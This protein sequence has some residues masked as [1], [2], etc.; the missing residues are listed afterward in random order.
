MR[1]SSG[2]GPDVQGVPAAAGTTRV[3]LLVTLRLYGHWALPELTNELARGP[4]AVDL[5]E[6]ATAA[7]L[8]DAL[9]EACGPRFRGKVFWPGGGLRPGVRL[10]VDDELMSDPTARIGGRLRR[11]ANVSVVL[12]APLLGG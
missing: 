10:F 2:T 12:L 9:G 1:S 11:G 4:V 8:L 3:K 5:P 6:H 7:A